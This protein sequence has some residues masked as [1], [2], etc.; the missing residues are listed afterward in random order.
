MSDWHSDLV[1]RQQQEFDTRDTADLVTLWQRRDDGGLMGEGLEAIRRILL[2]R[3]GY[4]PPEA[5]AT[6]PA[7]RA[8]HRR[9]APSHV[10]LDRDVFDAPGRRRQISTGARIFAWLYLLIGLAT[11]LVQVLRAVSGDGGFTLL[12]AGLSALQAAFFFIVLQVLAEG[13]LAARRPRATE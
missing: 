7:P 10:P 4:L 12:A 9:V 13:A 8:P 6:S 3:L 2:E 5:A 1:R 11:A